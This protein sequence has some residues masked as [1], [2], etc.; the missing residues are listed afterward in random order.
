[1]KSSTTSIRDRASPSRVRS[2]LWPRQWPSSR[3]K[4]R[5]TPRPAILL[6]RLC[7]ARE[8]SSQ[9]KVV[10]RESGEAPSGCGSL[11]RRASQREIWVSETKIGAA[12]PGPA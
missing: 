12:V 7:V 3:Q 6:E 5:T 9:A 2:S 10:G 8:E 4:H 11:N 1:M